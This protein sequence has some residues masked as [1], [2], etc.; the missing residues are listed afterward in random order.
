MARAPTLVQEQKRELN[1]AAAL[2]M[3]SLRS[4]HAVEIYCDDRF[5]K[6]RVTAVE[7]NGFRFQYCGSDEC[8][9]V[10]FSDLHSSWRFPL[11][12]RSKHYTAESIMLMI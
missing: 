11:S 1:A 2:M 10:L 9:R 12:S 7:A 5:W 4:R 3:I 8:G 6:A